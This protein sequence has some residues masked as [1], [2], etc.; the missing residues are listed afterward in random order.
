[1][2]ELFYITNSSQILFLIICTLLFT[3]FAIYLWI[4]FFEKSKGEFLFITILSPVSILVIM[5][6]AMNL[7]T[8][9]A[10]S[11]IIFILILAIYLV[12]FLISSKMRIEHK[13]DKNVA[14]GLGLYCGGILIIWL[15]SMLF[16]SP[17]VDF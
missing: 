16:K 5:T 4:K 3:A 8:L 7:Y 6:V 11:S 10:L 17:K 14:I 15:I 1:M 9:F 13:Y 2:A 12:V